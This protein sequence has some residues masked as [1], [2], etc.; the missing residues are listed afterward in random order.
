LNDDALTRVVAVRHGQT[1]WNAQTRIQGQIDID[2]NAHGRQQAQRLARA[3][4][5][6]RLDAVYASDLRRAADTA[7]PFADQAGLPVLTDVALRERGFGTFEGLTWAEVEQQHPDASRRWRERDAGFGPPG[8]E[9]LADFYGRAVSALAAIA[10][11]HRGQHIAIVTH[12]GVLDALYRA[13]SRIALDAPRTWQIGNAS[14]NRV[15]HGDRGFT[16]VGWNDDF[17]LEGDG[18]LDEASA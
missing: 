10:T 15:L 3:L 18:P 8:G 13:A 12:G 9:T 7:R 14:I 4:S 16:L 6:E 2:L 11:R 5:Q 1:D 17:H